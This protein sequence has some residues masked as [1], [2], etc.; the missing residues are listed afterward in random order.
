MADGSVEG[1]DTGRGEFSAASWKSHSGA[2]KAVRKVTG[3]EKRVWEDRGKKM[4]SITEEKERVDF[5]TNN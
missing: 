3:E 4:G 1:K 2:E 5:P